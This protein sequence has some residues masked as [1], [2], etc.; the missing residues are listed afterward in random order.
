MNELE[1]ITGGDAVSDD[2]VIAGAVSQTSK[3]KGIKRLVN[4]IF[5]WFE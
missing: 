2:P 4:W 3:R 5:S 1:Q